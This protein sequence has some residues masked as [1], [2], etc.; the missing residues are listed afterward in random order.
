[1]GGLLGRACAGKTVPNNQINIQTTY[2]N[3]T[4]FKAASKEGYEFVKW[5]LED[6]TLFDGKFPVF[7]DLT[8]IPVFKILNYEALFY[9]DNNANLFTDVRFIAT[10]NTPIDAA[11]MQ[12]IFDK[13]AEIS[14]NVPLDQQKYYVFDKWYATNSKGIKITLDSLRRADGNYYLTEN[15]TFKPGFIYK[16]YSI[17]YMQFDYYASLD[18]LSYK[19]LQLVENC[20]DKNGILPNYSIVEYANSPIPKEFLNGWFY[21]DLQGNAVAFD[22]TT[23]VSEDIV[24]V[25]NKGNV[26][27]VY[28]YLATFNVD[29]NANGGVFI[30]TK[31]NGTQQE[32]STLSVQGGYFGFELGKNVKLVKKYNNFNNYYQLKPNQNWKKLDNTFIA[33]NKVQINQNLTLSANWTPVNFNVTLHYN[34]VING[35]DTELTEIFDG[36]VEGI[37]DPNNKITLFNLFGINESD[38]DYD[39]KLY[40]IKNSLGEI[41]YI[42]KSYAVTGDTDV[43]AIKKYIKKAILFDANGIGNDAYFVGENTYGENVLETFVTE[44]GLEMFDPNGGLYTK[45]EVDEPVDQGMPVRVN[46]V[47]NGWATVPKADWSKDTIFYV[48]KDA[49]DLHHSGIAEKKMW[50]GDFKT[51]NSE[52]YDWYTGQLK[53]TKLY[54]QWIPVKTRVNYYYRGDTT[55]PVTNFPNFDKYFLYPNEYIANPYTHGKVTWSMTEGGQ[56]II[57]RGIKA[58]DYNNITAKDLEQIYIDRATGELFYLTNVPVY[59]S[60]AIGTPIKISVSYHFDNNNIRIN[61]YDST[62]KF[63]NYFSESQLEFET[64]ISGNMT[65]NVLRH[66]FSIERSTVNFIDN[67]LG[68]AF[69]PYA[70]ASDRHGKYDETTGDYVIDLD[71]YEAFEKVPV[72]IS[73]DF[74]LDYNAVKTSLFGF[75]DRLV[76]PYANIK[77]RL[78]YDNSTRK[79][80]SERLGW[81][82]NDGTTFLDADFEN[83][84]SY[85][86]VSDYVTF[87]IDRVIPKLI[88]N[89]VVYIYKTELTGKWT[90]MPNSI[91]TLT[92]N[93]KYKKEN[94]QIYTIYTTRNIGL[95]NVVNDPNQ[96]FVQN[97]TLNEK[98]QIT[99][100]QGQKIW[101]RRTWTINDRPIDRYIY[102]F[103]A[104]TGKYQNQI[105]CMSLL[106]KADLIITRN[107]QGNYVY[108]VVFD[109]I[110]KWV[111][112]TPG[113]D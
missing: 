23:K 45:K 46:Y 81:V 89:R 54:A 108:T 59:E 49:H 17:Q 91:D 21:Y 65:G 51:Y 86:V 97:P 9:D 63:N 66:T 44:I 5:T 75:G 26:L 77:G 112:D 28:P 32:T 56:D 48:Y 64:D 71:V 13:Q 18:K 78:L 41:Q 57:D 30:I 27:T 90:R 2:K 4:T 92:I 87:N 40:I 24:D 55:K 29:L 60:L 105:T 36:N 38:G 111:E 93:Y 104:K 15:L 12:M 106:K 109:A 11:H 16:K 110:E 42:D 62:G 58:S 8:V 10:I 50:L 113:V 43:Y 31:T 84:A 34:N 14:A 98:K 20:F 99:T 69:S 82:G 25:A 33:D 96:D 74:M 47:F 1:M 68:N 19:N 3:G 80:Y 85:K 83:P 7:E 107:A 70:Y 76:Y 101:I 52:L 39:L 94:E 103:D 73:A 102:D 67:A 53:V 79:Y 37:Q 100:D 35:V 88:D 95:K 6:G 61:K 72:K 22:R